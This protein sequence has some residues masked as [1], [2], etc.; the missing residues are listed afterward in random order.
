[1]SEL[2]DPFSIRPWNTAHLTDL[3]STI[4]GQVPGAASAPLQK[5]ALRCLERPLS[6]ASF[7]AR[8]VAQEAV[9]NYPPCVV[10]HRA[11]ARMSSQEGRRPR[12]GSSRSSR[13]SSRGAPRTALAVTARDRARDRSPERFDVPEQHKSSWLPREFQGLRRGHES[14]R[15]R[16]GS[17]ENSEEL[18]MAPACLMRGSHLPPGRPNSGS[19]PVLPEGS[20]RR[21]KQAQTL[22]SLVADGRPGNNKRDPHLAQCLQGISRRTAVATKGARQIAEMGYEEEELPSL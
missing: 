15:P 9:A 7:L 14:P 12:S 18:L 3:A 19:M 13:G 2:A 4:D 21:V 11:R 6:P 5:V 10:A 16:L 17:F 22:L 20:P 8:K 1:M